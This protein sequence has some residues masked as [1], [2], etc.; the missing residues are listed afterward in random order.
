MQVAFR[1]SKVDFGSIG[2]EDESL[3]LQVKKKLIGTVPA[4]G[5]QGSSSFTTAKVGRESFNVRE[6][7]EKNNKK[8]L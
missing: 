2:L 3:H 7:L 6:K 8:M 1:C 4:S 5:R